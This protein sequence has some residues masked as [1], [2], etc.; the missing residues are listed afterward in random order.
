[1]HATYSRTT[2]EVVSAEQVYDDESTTKSVSTYLHALLSSHPQPPLSLSSSG[3]TGRPISI[4]RVRKRARKAT[5]NKQQKK[6]EDGDAGN[7]K[8]SSAPVV[9]GWT[10]T[11]VGFNLN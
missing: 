1:M 9:L 5:K 2:G 4:S 11:G 10:C 3:N 7:K 8:A 6:K